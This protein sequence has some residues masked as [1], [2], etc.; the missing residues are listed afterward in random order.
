MNDLEDDD[1]EYQPPTIER[2][3]RRTWALCGVVY[4]S[5][6]EQF[7]D[8]VEAVTGHSRLL[9]WIDA[10]DLQGEFEPT[11]WELVQSDL[12]TPERQQIIY[13]TWRSEGLAVLAWAL[14]VFDLPPHDQQSDPR[15]VT[16]SLFFLAENTLARADELQLRSP[17]E[18]EQFGSTQT[19]IHW[20]L[21]DF[22]IR[23]EATDFR[24]FPEW[25]WYQPVDLSGLPFAEDD[26]AIHGLP[27]AKAPPAEV[28]LC[29]SIAHERHQ[30][31][32]WL[33]GWHEIY[34]EVDTST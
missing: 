7:D 26:L 11:E 12:G 13:G 4:R 1:F 21:R 16:D 9:N 5:F 22:S 18:L 27:I 34:S 20:R 25:S 32:N 2:V 28:G 30:A 19:A 15:E 14:G 24:K 6:L 8:H 23:P 17:E 31:I 33:Q 29:S 10:I 3:R